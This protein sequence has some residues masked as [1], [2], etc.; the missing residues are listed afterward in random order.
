M[1]K[2]SFFLFRP[3]DEARGGVAFLVG[4]DERATDDGRDGETGDGGSA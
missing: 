4:K 3:R 2:S 1:G